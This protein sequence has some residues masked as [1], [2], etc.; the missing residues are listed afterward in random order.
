M[1]YQ[2]TPNLN[3]DYL[4]SP[5][6]TFNGTDI[7]LSL[8]MKFVER[9]YILNYYTLGDLLSKVGG[10]RASIMPIIGYFSPLFV[11]YF[12]LELARVIKK[13]LNKDYTDKL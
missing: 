4:V 13:S 5:E 1:S 8:N 12:L 2:T 7:V 3:K 10:L 9:Q 6:P 11:L